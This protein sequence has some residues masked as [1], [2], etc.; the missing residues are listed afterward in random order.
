MITQKPN[1]KLHYKEGKHIIWLTTQF[2]QGQNNLNGIFIFRTVQELSK[3]YNI[4]VICLYPALPPVISI[5]KNPNNMIYLIKARKNVFPSRMVPPDGLDNAKVLYIKYPRFLRGK[6][7]FTEGW[8]AYLAIKRI[9]KKIITPHTI[10]HANWLFPEGKLAFIL[11]KKFNLPYIVTL[12]GADVRNIEKGTKNWS[13]AKNI[14]NYASKVTS[15]SNALLDKGV[16]KKI[17]SGGKKTFITHNIYDFTKFYI[18]NKME[19]RRAINL[20]SDVKMI[21]YV[22]SLVKGK[23]VSSLIKAFSLMNSTNSETK[24]IIIGSGIEEKYLK[25]LV[26]DENLNNVVLPGRIFP[27]NLINYYNAADVFCLPSYSEGLPNVIVESMLC[28]TPV[29]GSSVDEI[30]YII[31]DGING[32]LIDPYS[33]TDIAEKLEKALIIQWDR[34]KIRESVSFLSPQKVL[35]EYKYIYENI[36]NN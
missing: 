4:T 24:L 33:I 35:N 15:V 17:I 5:L 36:N 26:V 6:L 14:L 31:K 25:K 19:A 10:L 3:Y 32:F 28:G 16:S 9:V 12:R 18:N 8:F 2:P 34:S 30:P 1:S 11:S 21:L 7:T 13:E 23:N 29:V 20:S 22:G 27:D